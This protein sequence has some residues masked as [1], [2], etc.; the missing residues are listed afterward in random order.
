MQVF[1]FIFHGTGGNDIATLCY[2]ELPPCRR[3]S[4][5]SSCCCFS[6]K[7][8]NRFKVRAPHLCASD[9]WQG[10]CVGVCIGWG[11][12]CMTRGRHRFC[13]G[14]HV[15]GVFGPETGIRLFVGGGE[16]EIGRA[17]V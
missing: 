5:S 3:D 11:G 10:S 12:I 2:T 8:L 6:R 15:V 7:P 17:H 4:N 13:V 1:L 9:Q 16:G 14:V